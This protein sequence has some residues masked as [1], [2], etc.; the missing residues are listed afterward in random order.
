MH[1]QRPHCLDDLRE[2][3]GKVM[4]V[5]THQADRAPLTVGQYAEAVVLDFVNPAWGRRR[6]I[7][8]ARQARIEEGKGLLGTQAHASQ[9]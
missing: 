6:P 7:S 8:Q 1:W 5:A 9:A 2:V 3:A 4:A